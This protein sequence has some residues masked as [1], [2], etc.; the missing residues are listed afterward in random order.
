MSTSTPKPSTGSGWTDRE[1]LAYLLSLLEH[2]GA[3][4]NIKTAPLP[5]GRSVIACERM[6]S[7]LKA[8]LKGE[9]DAL[10]DGAAMRGCTN[11]DATNAT[12]ARDSEGSGSQ[13]SKATRGAAA[14]KRKG[15]DGAAAAAYADADADADADVEVDGGVKKRSRNA[16]AGAKARA[17]AKDSTIEGRGEVEWEGGV[18]KEEDE[19]EAEEV[20]TKEEEV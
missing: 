12:T 6:L 1:R 8:A 10:R 20:D 2:S 17:R 9:L 11:G 7:R 16:K 18:K 14:R 19:A 5:S 3:K 13:A 15:G 4:P